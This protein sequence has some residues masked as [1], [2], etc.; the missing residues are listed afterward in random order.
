M[1]P[2]VWSV[3]EWVARRLGGS[4]AVRSAR[5]TLMQYDRGLRAA[6]WMSR[7][8]VRRLTEGGVAGTAGVMHGAALLPP[9]GLLTA[10]AAAGRA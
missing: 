4:P 7:G 8:L 10:L 5:Q 3:I 6:S 9:A 1:S 2:P